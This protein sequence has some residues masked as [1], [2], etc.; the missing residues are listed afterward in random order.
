M[1][2]CWRHSVLI[3]LLAT[4]LYPATAGSKTAVSRSSPIAGAT[5]SVVTVQTASE[6]G[7]AFAYGASGH[8]ITNAHVV[9]DA[10]TVRVLT[11][12]G[13]VVVGTV[14]RLDQGLDLAEIDVPL[15]L[16]PLE[17]DPSPVRPGDRVYA[18]GAPLG[19]AGSVSNGI[20][21]A[22]RPQAPH[23][24]EIQTDVPLNPGNSGGPL[25]DPQG[26]VIGINEA[27]LGQAAGISFSIPIAHVALLQREPPRHASPKAASVPTWLISVVV[28]SMIVLAV[29]GFGLL[30]RRR[31]AVRVTLRPAKPDNQFAPEPRVMLKP[32][33]SGE[34]PTERE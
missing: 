5:V 16:P 2:S 28:L 33:A 19:L 26:Q 10:R 12:S 11:S 22:L 21:S 24:A 15:V 17:R 9:G 23:G 3:G 7:S 30:R 31:E 25:I 18:I 6:L 20:V 34:L 32:K 4:L 29:G 14:D 13:N 8:L 1:S 27:T